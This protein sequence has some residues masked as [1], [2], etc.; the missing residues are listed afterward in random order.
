LAEGPG[1]RRT[2]GWGKKKN[3]RQENIECGERTGTRKPSG[4]KINGGDPK[5]R[6]TVLSPVWDMP[7]AGGG[8]KN[9]QKTE[10]AEF[11]KVQQF[12]RHGRSNTIK[13]KKAIGGTQIEELLGCWEHS[14]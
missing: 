13:K 6:Q 10:I 8:E 12:D 5:T 7:F 14:I 3:K 9:D 2:G 11:L 4:G 1:G